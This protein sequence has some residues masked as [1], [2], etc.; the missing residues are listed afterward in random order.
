MISPVVYNVTLPKVN[1]SQT[2]VLNESYENRWFVMTRTNTFPFWKPVGTHVLVNNWA[3]G[4]VL[5]PSVISHQPSDCLNAEDCKSTTLVIFFL[6][7]LLQWLGFAL[8]P[9][10]FLFAQRL[11]R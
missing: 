4:W 10:P 1:G 6:P 5:E 9:L 11:A 7:Q 3:N 8:L 2:V